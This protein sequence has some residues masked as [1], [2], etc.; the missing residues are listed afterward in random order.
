MKSDK[1]LI[2]TMVVEGL[3]FYVMMSFTPLSIDDIADVFVF[4][5]NRRISTISDFFV[6]LLMRLSLFIRLEKEY[7]P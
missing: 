1:F 2:S 5:T 7:I 4:G 6:V 3:S